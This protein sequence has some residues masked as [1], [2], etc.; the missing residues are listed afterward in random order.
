M[1]KRPLIG[2]GLTLA[3]P[4]L[5]LLSGLVV[6]RSGDAVLAR[7]I[8]AAGS[9]PALA[10]LLYGLGRAIARRQLGVDVLAL[11]AIA[12]ALALDEMLTATVIAIMLAGGR[13]LE[14][15]AQAR[16]GQDMAALLERAPRFANRFEG[17]LLKRITIDEVAPGD[18]LLVKAGETVP[19][20]GTLEAAHAT[21]D[22]SSLTGETRHARCRSGQPLRSGALNAGGPFEMR[23]ARRAADS[24]FAGIV[25]LVATARNAR[26]PAAR[27]ADRYAL[28]FVPLTL[29][30]AGVVWLTT[31]DAVRTL[32]VLVVATPCPLL[33]AVPIAIVAGMSSCARRGIL[34]KGGAMLE[35]LAVARTLF[36]DKTGTL[37]GGQARLVGI[38]SAAGIAQDEVLRVAASLDQM[39]CHAIA[40]AV[41][42]AARQRGLVLS[43]PQAVSETPGA[44]LRGHVDGAAVAIGRHDYVCRDAATAPWALRH[45]SHAAVEGSAAVFVAV[46]GRLIGALELA[47][48]IR[49]ETPRALRLLRQSGIRRIAMLTGDSRDIAESIAASIGVDEVFAEMTPAGKLDA[50]RAAQEEAVT[51]MVGDGINDAPALAAADVGVAMGARGAAAAAESA[52]V[53]VLVD[54]LDRLAEALRAARQARVI[55]IQSAA[56]GMGLSLLAMLLAALGYLSPLSGA[57]VQEVIDV[58]AILNALRALRIHPLRASRHPISPAQSARLQGEHEALARVLDT[59]SRL[60]GRLIE[61]DGREARQQLTELET[62]LRSQLLTHERN[63]E[64]ETYPELARLLGGDDPMAMMS[65]A[66]REI[67]QLAGRL[68]HLIEALPAE[69]PDG[70]TLSEIQRILYSLDAILRLHFAQE[71]EL[72]HTLN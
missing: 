5:A 55:A 3:V 8:W 30:L 15:Y 41:V 50:I 28:W 48:Q 38:E 57:V 21:L 32:A 62:L 18:L 1:R 10:Q 51:I 45:G 46:E 44:G 42:A 61:L 35:R 39:S 59:L 40:I 12:G 43:L 34:I 16:A 64:T 24:T 65:R 14:A 58:V 63:E 23:A 69:G 25:K 6:W 13:A 70:A 52:G 22:E 53:V 37:T 31:R 11:F 33:L 56:A 71:E 7:T 49:I 17:A 26:S 9:L 29:A 36:F 68:R 47:D 2:S 19:V 27:L 60:A 72:Y 54:R 20:D 4:V 67:F 66:H